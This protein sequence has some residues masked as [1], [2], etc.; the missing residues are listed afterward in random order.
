M[1]HHTQHFLSGVSAGNPSDVVVFGE[2]DDVEAT[3]EGERWRYDRTGLGTLRFRRELPDRAGL[4]PAYVLERDD[5][6]A[7]AWRRA[8]RAW[9]RGRVP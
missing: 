7:D 8:R 6:V 3:P 1:E 2:P 9:R 5:R 4:W